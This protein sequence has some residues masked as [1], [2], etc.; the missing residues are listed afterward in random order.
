MS[1][2]LSKKNKECGHLR[3]GE[4]CRFGKKKK[5]VY[6][7][8]RTPIKKNKAYRIPKRSLTKKEED[9]IYFPLRD[10]FL[11]EHPKCE[12]GREGCFRDSTDVH[13][14]KGRGKYYLDVSTWK[15]LNR[16]CHI[17]VNENTEEAIKLGL[18]L[19]RK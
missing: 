13:H 9:A 14:T 12:C 17:W 18:I 8:Q 1:T 11:I 4:T 10:K 6:Y 3:C 2:F 19:I 7:L 15:A 16:I 5:K